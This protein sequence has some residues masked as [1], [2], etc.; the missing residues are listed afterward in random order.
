M[1]SNFDKTVSEHHDFSVDELLTP[2]AL[3]VIIDNKVRDPEMSEFILQAEGLLDLAGYKKQVTPEKIKTWFSQNETSIKQAVQGHK[4]NTFIL[5]SLTR[6]K[7]NDPL[8][9]AMYDAMLAIS[10]SD[11]E[12]HADESDLIKSASTLWG[13]VRPPFKVVSRD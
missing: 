13:Y 6:Y 3:A 9:E 5:K 1:T 7:D 2:L 10:I 12:Y 11:K 8:I 4:K